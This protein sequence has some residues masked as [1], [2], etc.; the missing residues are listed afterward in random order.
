[1]PFT[2][3]VVIMDCVVV[4]RTSCCGLELKVMLRIAGNK[5]LHFLDLPNTSAIIL[6]MVQR[7]S[8]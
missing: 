4:E 2:L 6:S 8:K 3:T 7:E 1:M 5:M